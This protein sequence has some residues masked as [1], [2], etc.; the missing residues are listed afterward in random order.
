ECLET[1]LRHA[2]G[3][4][5]PAASG[6]PQV[7]FVFSGQGGQ[8]WGMGRELLRQEPV[9]RRAIERCDEILRRHADWSLL[10]ELSADESQSRLDRTEIAQP[11]L[12]ALQVA[13][14]E[15]WQSWGVQPA[16]VL[17]HSVGEIAAAAVAG[18]LS[19]DDA[20]RLV[21]HRGRLMQRASGRGRM[22]SV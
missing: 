9:F 15:L 6:K 8:W 3:H 10:A 2:P 13:L 19:W 4:E 14:A 11:A 22:V 12:V 18:V 20:L 16:A 7:T 21:F 5:Q 17:G 1:F